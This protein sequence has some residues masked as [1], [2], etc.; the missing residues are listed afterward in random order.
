VA[1]WVVP[2]FAE[3]RELG[4]GGSG[5]ASAD[6][7]GGSHLLYQVSTA[8]QATQYG[9][10]QLA[11]SPFVGSFGDFAASP[12][13]SK[14]GFITSSG[15]GACTR[16]DAPHVLDT[17][18]GAVTSP[19]LPAGGGPD[20]YAVIGMWFDR[21]GTPYVSLAGN[22]GDCSISGTPTAYKLAGGAWVQAGTGVDK[23]AY[24][25]GNWVA[26]ATGITDLTGGSTQTLTISGGPGTT[27]VTV[28]NVPA[29][30]SFAWE[31]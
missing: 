18:T 30:G 15:A 26:Q 4:S 22:P 31:P 29:F 28:S 19:T 23:D 9:H 10:D 27:P 6:G 21:A 2:G 7:G 11:G 5:Q 12:A 17:T 20:G 1:T 3:E 25:P 13:T 14:V 24:G 8:G 16:A